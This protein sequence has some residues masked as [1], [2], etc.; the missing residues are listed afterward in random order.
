MAL[1][2]TSEKMVTT[3]D[4]GNMGN[5]VMER[6]MATVMVMVMVMENNNKTTPTPIF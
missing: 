1:I 4:M 6:N 5:M 3:M 2:W